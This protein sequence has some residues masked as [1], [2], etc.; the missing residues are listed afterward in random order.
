MEDFEIPEQGMDQRTLW[1]YVAP[2]ARA[3]NGLNNFSAQA[4]DDWDLMWKEGNTV[5]KYPR[6]LAKGKGGGGVPDGLNQ[7]TWMVIVNGAPAYA[8]FV[9]SE[10]RDTPEP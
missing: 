9:S 3:L 4:G 1:R 8:D 10:P 7:R 6:D 5:L 2:I